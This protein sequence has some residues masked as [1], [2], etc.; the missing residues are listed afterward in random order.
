MRLIAY[1]PICVNLRTHTCWTK[2]KKHGVC[3]G[4]FLSLLLKQLRT[5]NFVNNI[6]FFSLFAVDA[7]WRLIKIRF[8]YFDK[9]K[10]IYK[11]IMKAKCSN[12]YPTRRRQKSCILICS[13]LPRLFNLKIKLTKVNASKKTRRNLIIIIIKAKK[14]ES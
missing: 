12:I 7:R 8:Y 6:F 13:R 5:I 3:D 14:G 9:I 4:F 11:K 1:I 2:G 10:R